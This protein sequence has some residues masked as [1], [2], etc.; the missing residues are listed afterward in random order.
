M[1][2]IA[3]LHPGQGCQRLGMTDHLEP[4][5]KRPERYWDAAQAHLSEPLR[6]LAHNGPR[7]RLDT[8]LTAQLAV[9]VTNAMATDVLLEAGSDVLEPLDLGFGSC[10][11][12]VARPAGSPRTP[13]RLPTCRQLRWSF[14]TP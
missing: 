3:F 7:D 12:E 1:T 14:A 5:L 9:Y 13:S 6:E 4:R 10:R 11:L 2:G 8:D